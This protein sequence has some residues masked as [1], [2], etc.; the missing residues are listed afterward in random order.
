[1]VKIDSELDI[2]AGST[3]ATASSTSTDLAQINPVI[4]IL[5]CD[6]NPDL[7]ICKTCFNRDRCAECASGYRL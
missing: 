1:M 5:D 7:M 2:D 6:D 3:E 4:Y